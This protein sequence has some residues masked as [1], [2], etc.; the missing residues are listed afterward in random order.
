MIEEWSVTAFR[1]VAPT[2]SRAQCN[3]SPQ[4]TVERK[5]EAGTTYRD[6]EF[7]Y[8][9][10]RHEYFAYGFVFLANIRCNLV[11][12]CLVNGICGQQPS[13]LL[14]C[15]FRFLTFPLAVP[16][17]LAVPNSL[18]AVLLPHR[19]I[20]AHQ[21]AGIFSWTVNSGFIHEDGKL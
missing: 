9:A 16:L 14:R 12:I 5:K 2:H 4:S 20:T 19:T 17:F 13:C 1:P 3:S 15:P 11:F 21:I 6:S 7:R 18:L 10:R 8:G